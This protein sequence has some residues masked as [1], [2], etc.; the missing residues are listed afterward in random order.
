M[1]EG[2][3]GYTFCQISNGG[4][5]LEEELRGEIYNEIHS[6]GILNR[7]V[8]GILPVGSEVVAVIR[9]NVVMYLMWII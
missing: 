7:L 2:I 9:S 3:S 5:S 1:T 4:S 6:F 8:S